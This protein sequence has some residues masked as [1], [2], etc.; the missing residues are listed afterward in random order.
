M[1]Y[2][3]EASARRWGLGELHLASYQLCGP[4]QIGKLPWASV[5]QL[6][7]GDLGVT[8]LLSLLYCREDKMTAYTEA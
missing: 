2:V 8:V 5:P 7:E 1:A 3:S 6:L 4:R